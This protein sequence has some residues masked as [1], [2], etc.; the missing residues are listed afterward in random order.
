MNQITII[1]IGLMGGSFAKAVKHLHLCK[2]IV[3]FDCDTTNARLALEL[4]IIDVFTKSVAEA[5]CDADV[6][7]IATP[8]AQF[9]AILRQIK[10]ALKKDA[11]LTDVS[12]IKLS[13]L[14]TAREI[15]ADQFACFVPGHPIAGSEKSGAA[16]ASTDLFNGKKMILTPTV[17]TN[18]DAIHTI[19]SLWQQIGAKVEIMDAA[20]HDEIL[21][22]TSHLPQL[23]A[24]TL[25]DILAEHPHCENLFNYV[26]TGFRDTTRI[27]ASNPEIWS[28]IFCGNS[29]NVINNANQLIHK[30][31][32]FVNAIK[33]NDIQYIKTV[34]DRA[35]KSREQLDLKS[36]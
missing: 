4:K 21:A 12:S 28:D 20:M 17:E 9:S 7:L 33:N 6:I 13:I 29:K 25:M 23:T 14:E 18:P 10:S 31:E 3:G 2:K 36:S 32:L 19:Q 24:F 27:A 5:V 16:A 11:I 22:M 26:G 1:G 30:L 34:M 15:L 8:I 35:K